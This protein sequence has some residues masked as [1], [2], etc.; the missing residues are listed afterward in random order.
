MIGVLAA[1]MFQTVDH[2]SLRTNVGVECL[3]KN[4]FD[5]SKRMDHQIPAHLITGVGKAVWKFVR[6]RIQQ[7]AWCANRAGC[8]NDVL[9]MKVDTGAGGIKIFDSDRRSVIAQNTANSSL[10]DDCGAQSTC[11]LHIGNICT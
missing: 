3:V 8:Q 2:A 1:I 5:K 6:F 11:P 9:A 7:D 4:A 10:G